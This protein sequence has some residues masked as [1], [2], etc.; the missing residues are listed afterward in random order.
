METPS[1]VYIMASRRNGT[2]YLGST[3]DLI[4][5]AWEHREGLVEGFTKRHGCKL[6]V[7][8]EQHGDLASARLRERRMREWNRAWKLREIEGM[9]PEW[10]DLYERIAR[11]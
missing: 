3:D 8:Y 2:I 10:E 4:R 6:L 9:N 7:W 5:R 11:P 1:Y